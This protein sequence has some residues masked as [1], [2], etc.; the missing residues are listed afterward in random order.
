MRNDLIQERIGRLVDGFGRYVAAYDELVPFSSEQLA[1]HRRTLGLRRQAESVRAAVADEQFVLSLRR[2]LI[3]WGIGGRASY[4]APQDEFAAALQAVLPELEALEP[5]TIDSTDLPADL[6][7]RLWLLIDSLGVVK[8]K[9]K[10]VAGTKT[11]RLPTGQ[12][13]SAVHARR[14]SSACTTGAASA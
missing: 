8:N 12:E 14:R 7:D 3:A 1:A 5:L 6:A 2:T 11:Q 4:L 10:I 9:A 13:R